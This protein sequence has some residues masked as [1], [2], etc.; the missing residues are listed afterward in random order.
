MWFRFHRV[1]FYIAPDGDWVVMASMA[2]PCAGF[3]GRYRVL[4]EG[5][6]FVLAAEGTHWKA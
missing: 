3:G 6:G 5:D 4:T 2:G 1:F